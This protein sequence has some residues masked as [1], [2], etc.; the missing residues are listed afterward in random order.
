MNIL[1]HSCCAPCTNQCV[2][3]L[4]Q[5]G[6]A[7]TLFWFNHNIHPF[8]EYKARR[9]AL[10]SYAQVCGAPLIEAGTYGLRDFLPQAMENIDGRCYSCYEVRLDETARQAAEQGFDGFTSSLLISPYQNHGLICD[11][12]NEAAERHKVAFV[13]HDFRPHFRTG[14]QAARDMELYM[15]KYCGCIFSEEE[16]YVKKKK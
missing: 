9:N 1:L 15:Q 6:S 10:R 3:V 8:Q 14:Q 2:E 4:R 5:T 12:A 7:P 13:H 11:L 16:R